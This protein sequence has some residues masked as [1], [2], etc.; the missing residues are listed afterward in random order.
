MFNKRVIC[1]ILTSF[2]WIFISFYLFVLIIL[3][4]KSCV[5]RITIFWLTIFEMKNTKITIFKKPKKWITHFCQPKKLCFCQIM[6]YITQKEKMNFDEV[7]FWIL[8]FWIV[9]FIP[10]EIEHSIWWMAVLS[11]EIFQE[12]F[13]QK[14]IIFD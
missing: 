14:L 4:S 10:H 6:L 1:D 13:K 9:H 7:R 8:G 11:V 2:P 3:F 12:K 5:F